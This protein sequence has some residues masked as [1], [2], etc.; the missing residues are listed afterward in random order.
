[1]TDVGGGF[2]FFQMLTKIT[3][4]DCFRH[5]LGLRAEI[6]SPKQS[7]MQQSC[8]LQSP[9]VFSTDMLEH[10]YYTPLTAKCTD[11]IGCITFLHNGDVHQANSLFTSLSKQ[12]TEQLGSYIYHMR[13]SLIPYIT[14]LSKK[15]EE[16]HDCKSCTGS[17]KMKHGEQL[18]FLNISHADILSTLDQLNRISVTDEQKNIND[19]T[20]AL[21]GLITAIDGMTRQ[22]FLV[23]KNVLIPKII[24]AQNHI[25]A[26]H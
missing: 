16:G 9:A 7:E 13:Y 25:H 18:A 10:Q 14:E 5:R 2:L 23:D 20:V 24:E 11:A 26:H 3:R 8:S 21:H 22:L 1:M 12:L 6:H 17:C 15:E 19:K 4:I